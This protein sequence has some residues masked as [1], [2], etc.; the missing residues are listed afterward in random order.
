MC[1]LFP[2]FDGRP[3]PP[4]LL[5]SPLRV[6]DTMFTHPTHFVFP[7]PSGLDP[8]RGR[9][10]RRVPAVLQQVPVSGGRRQPRHRVDAVGFVHLYSQFLPAAAADHA[11]ADRAGPRP[12]LHIPLR[13]AS[14]VL[15]EST[16]ICQRMNFIR[17]RRLGPHDSK[18]F[19]LTYVT[20][21]CPRLHV[22]VLFF[23]FVVF[24]L[25]ERG[26]GFKSSRRRRGRT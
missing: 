2:G 9:H 17:D 21:I 8:V 18:S 25:N 14:V 15:V 11:G 3:N 10:V 5:S 4:A 19:L 22:L 26:V 1:T 12:R 16:A 23:C 20:I 6:R 24:L 7:P 13:Q